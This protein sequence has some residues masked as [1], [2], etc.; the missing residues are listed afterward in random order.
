M[1]QGITFVNDQWVCLSVELDIQFKKNNNWNR[2]KSMWFQNVSKKNLGL[3]KIRANLL[4]NIY[5]L[6]KL[7][8]G[9]KLFKE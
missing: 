3:L 7:M 1:I 5:K 8:S 4:I 9:L 6:K 2:A